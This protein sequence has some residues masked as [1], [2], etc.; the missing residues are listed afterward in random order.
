[1]NPGGAADKAGL[2]IT[3]KLL[4]VSSDYYNIWYY[5][6][7]YYYYRYFFISLGYSTSINPL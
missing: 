6:C 7:Y 5:C 1:V 4:S 2:A 3:D